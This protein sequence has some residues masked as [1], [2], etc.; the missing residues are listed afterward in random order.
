MRNR[1]TEHAKQMARECGTDK[2]NV[3]NKWPEYVQQTD[4]TCERNVYCK[5]VDQMA[6]EYLLLHEQ[7]YKVPVAQERDMKTDVNSPR[8]GFFCVV[9]FVCVY[10]QRVPK[11]IYT[12]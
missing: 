8:T 6:P 12:F 11:N 7:F 1:W 9:L 3:W 2:H 4:R 10:I 5:H